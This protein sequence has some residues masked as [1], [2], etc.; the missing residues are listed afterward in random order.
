MLRADDPHFTLRHQLVAFAR[1]HGIKPAALRFGC[2]R[3]T[4]RKW[5]RCFQSLGLHGLQSQ[6][7]A[8][9]SCPHK[10]KPTLEARVVALR[11][12]TPGFGA[13]RLIAEFDLPMG[14]DAVQ[15]ILR[16]HQLTRTPKRRQNDLRAIKAA[17][18][19]FTRFQMDVKYLTDLSKSHYGRWDWAGERPARA[20]GRSVT[21]A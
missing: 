13:R 15:R 5:L 3:S 2:S 11:R 10:T 20:C 17:Y 16:D 7:R 6:A 4:V 1:A 21:G 14:H 18:T 12:K 19:T 9:L 8:P